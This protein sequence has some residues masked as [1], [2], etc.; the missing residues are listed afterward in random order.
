M[1]FREDVPDEALEKTQSELQ[2]GDSEFGVAE[3]LVPEEEFEERV[4]SMHEAFEV[5]A[6]SIVLARMFDDDKI[7][8]GEYLELVGYVEDYEQEMEPALL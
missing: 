4:D 5:Y 1:R 7:T 3:E 6:A 8:L 2:E